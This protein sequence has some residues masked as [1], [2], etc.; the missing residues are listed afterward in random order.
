MFSVFRCPTKTDSSINSWKPH[1]V[2]ESTIIFFG[3]SAA[4][5]LWKPKTSFFLA[6]LKIKLHNERPILIPKK[7]SLQIQMIPKTLTI[8][9]WINSLG[10]HWKLDCNDIVIWMIL[11]RNKREVNKACSPNKYKW[12][13]PHTNK[14][15]QKSMFFFVCI[16]SSP[17]FPWY[18]IDGFMLDCLREESENP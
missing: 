1:A 9:L 6:D 4:G 5:K 14:K 13:A 17:N 16:F 3:C 18:H 15:S 11:L 2:I 8:W 7:M 12:Q 10:L